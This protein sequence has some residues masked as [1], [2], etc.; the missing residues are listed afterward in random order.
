M[1]AYW[2]T[3][4]RQLHATG[5]AVVAERAL[6]DELF[7]G[8]ELSRQLQA[9]VSRQGE[10]IEDLEQLRDRHAHLMKVTETPPACPPDWGAIRIVPNLLE[11]WS[12]SEDRM[13]ERLL[14]ERDA[15]DLSWRLTHIAP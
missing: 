2:P 7:A 9:I 3:L 13:H 10:S 14:Y 4:G 15:D 5:V 12:E 11:F 8:R 1:L 6:A